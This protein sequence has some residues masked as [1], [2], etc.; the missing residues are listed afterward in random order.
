[1]PVTDDRRKRLN[2]CQDGEADMAP[3][4]RQASNCV[5]WACRRWQGQDGTPP[6]SGWV[7]TPELYISVSPKGLLQEGMSALRMPGG[8]PHRPCSPRLEE[9][10][11]RVGIGQPL[12][13]VARSRAHTTSVTIRW[14]GL[15][16]S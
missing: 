14:M 7:S 1:M 15:V 4:T 13:Q 2:N 12:G 10:H 9:P 16:R 3:P 6:A 8:P 11:H 5:R